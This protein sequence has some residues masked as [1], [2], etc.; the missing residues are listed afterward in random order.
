VVSNWLFLSLKPRAARF[1]TPSQHCHQDI[2]RGSSHKEA[3]ATTDGEA[4]KV[5]TGRELRLALFQLRAV[6]PNTETDKSEGTK[7]TTSKTP[8][9]LAEVVRENIV[10]DRPLAN[11]P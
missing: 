4:G 9:N 2:L 1:G 6:W 7:T 8:Q 11:F 10:L 5:S 3:S